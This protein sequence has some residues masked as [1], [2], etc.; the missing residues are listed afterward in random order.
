MSIFKPAENF[1]SKVKTK[2]LDLS[3]KSSKDMDKFNEIEDPSVP[4]NVATSLMYKSGDYHIPVLDI[5]MPCA[6]YPSSTEGKYHLYI[7][8][9][10]TWEE[11]K[12]LLDV[13]AEVGII[14]SGFANASIA[15]GYTAV[16]LPWVKKGDEPLPVLEEVAAMSE[17]DK[18][19]VEEI[20]AVA[21]KQVEDEMV[22]GMV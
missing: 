19:F 18:E 4:H 13:M 12:K 17:S 22:E 14:E 3:K 9:P 16:R 10:L 7:D 21:N 5:D 20:L 8:C 15:K 6:L 1:I 11:Y 2:A